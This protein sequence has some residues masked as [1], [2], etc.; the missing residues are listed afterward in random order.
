MRSPGQAGHVN[1]CRYQC[2]QQSILMSL[3]NIIKYKQINAS[4]IYYT[5]GIFKNS[6]LYTY[7]SLIVKF[8]NLEYSIRFVK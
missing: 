6:Y 8:S 4:F 3:T 2:R 5:L 7:V 1:V